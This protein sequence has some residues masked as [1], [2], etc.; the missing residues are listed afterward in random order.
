ML[1]LRR[2][3]TGAPPAPVLDPSQQGVVEHRGPVLRVLG[4]PGTGLSTVAVEVVAQRVE[5]G[6]A[7]AD[8]CLLLAPTR[9]AAARLRDAVT[10]RLGGT[11]T[12][13]LARTHQ[14]LGFGILREAAALVGDPTPR[15]LSGP[16]QDVIL[17]ELLAGHA[18][19]ESQAPPWPGSVHLRAWRE[20]SQ[21]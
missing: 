16:E 18:A 4:A 15:L 10:A 11:T 9:L 12:T 17:G 14:S 7:T 20:T 19:G 5:R 21:R 3:A 6:E 13:P 1:V 2:P 8:G